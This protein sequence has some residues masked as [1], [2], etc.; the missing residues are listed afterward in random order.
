M[1]KLVDSFLEEC[2]AVICL[3]SDLPSQ[4]ILLLARKK[5][6]L[7][8]F[9]ADGAAVK[10]LELGII[11]DAIIGDLD[12][13]NKSADAAAA[14]AAAAS[15]T[16]LATA[17]ANST[18]PS[19]SLSSRIVFIP[20]Q[21]RT[22]FAKAIDYAKTLSAER[23]MVLGAAGGMF[24]HVI[25]NLNLIVQHRCFFYT[26][27][28]IGLV[29]SEGETRFFNLELHNKI[30]IFGLPE[31]LVSS[32]GLKWELDMSHLCFPGANSSLNRT[33]ATEVE[34]TVHRGTALILIYESAVDDR[35]IW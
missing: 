32:R 12:S 6:R 17:A 9:A 1:T 30:S 11:P 20:D 25:N 5:H 28:L 18:P 13:W 33:I 10:M 27:P 24:D 22:D 29:M 23:V 31:A 14:T 2:Q 35:G 15:Y 21:D 7:P 26:P 16:E 8:L 19:I 34:L 4:E 3:N